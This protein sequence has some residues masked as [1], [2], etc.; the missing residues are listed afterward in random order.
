ML[1]SSSIYASGGKV[2]RVTKN[3]NCTAYR[4][5]DKEC[6]HNYAI[7][8]AHFQFKNQ[9]NGLLVAYDGEHNTLEQLASVFKHTSGTIIEMID[10]FIEG[11]TIQL[12]AEVAYKVYND[13]L[14]HLDAHLQAMQTDPVY[15]PPNIDDF[16]YMA[17][18]AT[19]IKWKASE[20]ADPDANP[21]EEGFWNRPY[22]PVFTAE[23][24]SVNRKERHKPA[25]PEISVPNSVKKMDAIERY[26]EMIGYV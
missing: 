9:R 4:I 7:D 10:Q 17:E 5:F 3:R 18:F 15:D 25:T 8:N 13:I 24:F 23:Q 26:L 21:V 12:E 14:K 1:Q 2:K 19:A 11:A 20:F 22:R 16:R 6:Q